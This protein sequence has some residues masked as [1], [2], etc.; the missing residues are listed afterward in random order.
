MSRTDKVLLLCTECEGL[1]VKS[2]AAE[3]K[4][5][6]ACGALRGAEMSPR[7]LSD[8]SIPKDD[9]PLA[10]KTVLCDRCGHD[11]GSHYTR[12]KRAGIVVAVCMPCA[13][14]FT[15]SGGSRA[16]AGA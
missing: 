2:L 8:Y 13:F 3:G 15:E 10:L 5:H 11:W 7:D 9:E 1:F 6:F 4:T 16:E 14:A 12:L